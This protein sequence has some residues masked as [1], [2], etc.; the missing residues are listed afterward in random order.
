M[1][2]DCTTGYAI[3]SSLLTIVR[4]VIQFVPL[5]F[6]FSK[7]GLEYFWLT[8]PITEVLTSL[9]GVVFYKQ[10]VNAPLPK[11]QVRDS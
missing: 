8:F 6:L 7:F 10:F 5:G 1:E 3:K 9:V 2:Q 11:G 4:T